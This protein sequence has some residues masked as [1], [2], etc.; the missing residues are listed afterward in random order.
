MVKET[1]HRVGRQPQPQP[2][3]GL[4]RQSQ[5]ASASAMGA[6]EALSTH[7]DN[8]PGLADGVAGVAGVADVRACSHPDNFGT[9]FSPSSQSQ[10]ALGMPKVHVSGPLRLVVFSPSCAHES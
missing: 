1:G 3:Q 9:I 5:S 2:V 4:S 6:R 10:P 7:F 8:V